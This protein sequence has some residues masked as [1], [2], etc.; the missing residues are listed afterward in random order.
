M[1]NLTAPRDPKWREDKVAEFKATTGVKYYM[2]GA[3]GF[4]TTTGLLTKTVANMARFAGVVLETTDLT[5]AAAGSRVRVQ[6][7]G[8]FEFAMAGATDAN[9]GDEVQLADDNTVAA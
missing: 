9:V 2:G 6:R 1:A 8:S 4:D 5:S 7:R 3:V